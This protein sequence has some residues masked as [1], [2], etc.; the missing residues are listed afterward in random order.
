MAETQKSAEMAQLS[1]PVVLSHLCYG[2]GDGLLI[3]G[4]GLAVEEGAAQLPKPGAA[5]CC[6][7]VPTLLKM[8]MPIAA[9]SNVIGP[10]DSAR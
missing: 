7:D 2:V 5:C 6:A 10:S 3:A 8:A 1:N 9:W 4:C